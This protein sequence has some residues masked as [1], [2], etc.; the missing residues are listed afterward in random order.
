MVSESQASFVAGVT[1]VYAVMSYQVCTSHTP[2]T[3][4]KLHVSKEELSPDYLLK[5][6]LFLILHGLFDTVR[7][8]DGL[9]F[10]V[11]I[12]KSLLLFFFLLSWQVLNGVSDDDVSGNRAPPDCGDGSLLLE[13]CISWAVFEKVPRQGKCCKCN[14]MFL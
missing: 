13:F 8:R 5:R 6:Y 7:D 14:F 1:S 12:C 11:Y 9:Q 2:L 3:A 4:L 10:C